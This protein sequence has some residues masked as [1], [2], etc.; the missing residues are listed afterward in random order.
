MTRPSSLAAVL[1]ALPLLAGCVTT[2]TTS[3][4]PHA[5]PDPP[6][7]GGDAAAPVTPGP[8]EVPPFNPPR[9]VVDDRSFTE[10]TVGVELTIQPSGEVS[11]VALTRSSGSGALDQALVEHLHKV[12]CR[13]QPPL[14]QPQV[15]RQEFTFRR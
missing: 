8:C 14:A 13:F 4:G 10:G 1:L 2:V 5:R 6:A 11:R 15:V 9:A 12:R 3:A 7:P